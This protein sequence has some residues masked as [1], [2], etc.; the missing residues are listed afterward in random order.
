M[1]W[2]LWGIA[3]GWG[4]AAIFYHSQAENDKAMNAA[5][6]VFMALAIMALIV[7]INLGIAD[8]SLPG[9]PTPTPLLGR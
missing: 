8:G 3:F 2:F 9:N 7:S 4:A 5:I 6:I 1:G